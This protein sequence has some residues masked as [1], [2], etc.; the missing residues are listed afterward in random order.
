METLGLGDVLCVGGE[1]GTK[2][3]TRFLG[4]M[5]ERKEVVKKSTGCWW[6]GEAGTKSGTY[7]VYYVPAL[8]HS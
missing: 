8:Q 6:K 4:V 7:F 2:V 5:T 3:M 1:G